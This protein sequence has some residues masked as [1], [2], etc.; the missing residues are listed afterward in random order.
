MLA[1]CGSRGNNLSV[2]CFL[3]VSL[4]A[5]LFNEMLMRDFGFRIYK[6]FVLMPEKIEDD[7]KEDDKKKSDDVRKTEDKKKGEEVK[8]DA[9]GEHSKDIDEDT[10]NGKSKCKEHQE[11]NGQEVG[12]IPKKDHEQV[13]F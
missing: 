11:E 13:N 7:R 8:D 3:Q 2:V 6:A 9:K 10:D 5:E 4:F 1:S 12:E